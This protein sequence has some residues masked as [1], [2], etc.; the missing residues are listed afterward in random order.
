MKVVTQP[1]L[2]VVCPAPDPD[3][4]AREWGE[5]FARQSRPACYLCGRALLSY[6]RAC[7]TCGAPVDVRR[8][9]SEPD[10]QELAE[11]LDALAQAEADEEAR[12]EHDEAQ[13]FNERG[14]D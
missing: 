14:R 13:W 6:S 7:M 5:A 8:G 1:Q 3:P 2:P 10:L 4:R 9:G 11:E 12:R